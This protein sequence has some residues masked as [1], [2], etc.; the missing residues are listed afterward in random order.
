MLK[1]RP[2]LV[3]CLHQIQQQSFDRHL[4]DRLA[5][6]HV[7]QHFRVGRC[8]Y[9][10]QQ[11]QQMAQPHTATL[12]VQQR[13]RLVLQQQHLVRCVQ[14]GLIGPEQDE[15]FQ[16]GRFPVVDPGG[17]ELLDRAL[18]FHRQRVTPHWAAVITNSSAQA[19]S[20]SSFWSLAGSCRNDGTVLAHFT[21]RNS[22]LAADSSSMSVSL[23]PPPPDA[24]PALPPTGGKSSG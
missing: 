4:T 21:A 3:L 19:S 8:L 11:Q 2:V 7:L 1:R 15:R 18:Q 5:E 10:G 20:S 24:I 16:A 12:F 23:L 17:T 14:T 13:D 22:S 6:Q 9:R